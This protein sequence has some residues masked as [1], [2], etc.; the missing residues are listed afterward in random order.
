[1]YFWTDPNKALNMLTFAFLWKVHFEILSFYLYSTRVT[2]SLKFQWWRL[3]FK[4]KRTESLTKHFIYF[5]ILNHLLTTEQASTSAQTKSTEISWQAKEATSSG[6]SS[7]ITWLQAAM[8]TPRTV[9]PR[10]TR[11]GFPPWLQLFPPLRQA[12]CGHLTLHHHH[13]RQTSLQFSFLLVL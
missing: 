3:S 10:A 11:Q 4:L 9:S 12:P 1:M 6:K 5:Q 7:W 2:P 8:V 13:R